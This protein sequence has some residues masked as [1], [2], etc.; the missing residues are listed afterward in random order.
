[1]PTRKNSETVSSDPGEYFTRLKLRWG[2]APDPTREFKDSLGVTNAPYL[3]YIFCSHWD[4]DHMG[5][6]DCVIRQLDSL[7]VGT[8]AP[9]ENY[10]FSP[11][12]Y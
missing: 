3:D 10:G 1:M 11:Y 2:R 6:M 9:A 4:H 12:N 7:N 8:Y 5:Y